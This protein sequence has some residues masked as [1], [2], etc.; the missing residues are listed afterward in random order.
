M[1]FR[2][3]FLLVFLLSQA[4]ELSVFAARQ[5]RR[6]SPW[7]GL[8]VEWRRNEES[9]R[10]NLAQTVQA[11]AADRFG[12]PNAE[13]PDLRTYV[14]LPEPTM[15]LEPRGTGEK[16]FPDI[17]S[18]VYPGN[19]PIAI[20]QVES[21]ETVTLEQA[22]YV[23]SRLAVKGVDLYLYVPIGMLQRAQDY[24]RIVGLDHAKFRTWRWTPNGMA[25]QEA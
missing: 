18:V 23:W 15:A 1:L 22:R 8:Q 7:R 9:R 21:S 6:R 13:N 17:V 5:P 2:S 19:Y 10:Y 25:V 12:F 20:A 24:A 14:N 16:V 11:I 4:R 3:V